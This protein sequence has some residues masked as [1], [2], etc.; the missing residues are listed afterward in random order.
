MDTGYPSRT[1]DA[2][3]EAQPPPAVFPAAQTRLS[4]PVFDSC[5]RLPYS[6]RHRKL[7]TTGLVSL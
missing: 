3:N 5:H 4:P 6:E 2:E 1:A 7:A